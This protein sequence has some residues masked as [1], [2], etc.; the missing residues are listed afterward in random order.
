MPALRPPWGDARARIG[1]LLEYS[2]LRERADDAT[3]STA[4]VCSGGSC[5]AVR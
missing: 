5:S 3:R 1:N 2:G 4:Q